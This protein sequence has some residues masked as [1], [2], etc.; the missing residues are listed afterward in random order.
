MDKFSVHLSNFLRLAHS[1]ALLVSDGDK[2]NLDVLL[3]ML[4]PVDKEIMES[5]FGLFGTPVMQ[6]ALIAEKYGVTASAIEEI[7]AK[8]I[9]RLSITPEWQMMAGQLSVVVKKRIGF[10]I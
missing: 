1:S 4:G 6:P 7:V 10:E 8:D 9:R 5:Y 3:T 2:A